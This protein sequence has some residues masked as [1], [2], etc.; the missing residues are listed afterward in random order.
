M[1]F[2]IHILFFPLTLLS[3]I[4]PSAAGIFATTDG[5]IDFTS[6]A[7]LELITASSSS[8]RGALNTEKNTF[9][10]TIGVQSFR[11]FNSPLQHEHFNEKFM[12]SDVY[13]HATFQGKMIESIDINRKGETTVRAKGQLTIHGVSQERIIRSTV[14]VAEGKITIDARFSVLLSDHN[15]SIPKI[16]SQKIAEEIEVHVN[17]EMVQKSAS[18]R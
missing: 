13:P 2:F 10:F 6:N 11:G 4:S 9:A 12:E 17:A 15:I 18:E 16:V 5:K 3:V 1:L 14:T 7:P 8:L